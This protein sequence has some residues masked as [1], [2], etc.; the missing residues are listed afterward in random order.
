M[1]SWTTS[2]FYSILS[3]GDGLREH[4][5]FTGSVGYIIIDYQRCF[6]CLGKKIGSRTLAT[7]CCMNFDPTIDDTFQNRFT[8]PGRRSGVLQIE[9]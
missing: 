4:I 2:E 6:V 7:W 3:R 9:G 5:R 8:E 1:S